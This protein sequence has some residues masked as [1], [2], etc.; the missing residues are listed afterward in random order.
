[1]TVV[2]LAASVNA[3]LL[4][5]AVAGTVALVVVA[6]LD[7]FSPAPS[8]RSS[9]SGRNR[10]LRPDRGERA[11]ALLVALAAV[12]ALLAG[13][14]YEATR[15]GVID[16]MVTFL[17]LAAVPLASDGMA[18]TGGT[19][20]G[21]GVLAAAGEYALAAFGHDDDLA[22]AM[23][24]ATAL[25]LVCGVAGSTTAGRALRVVSGFGIAVGALL[26]DP[27]P[28]AGRPVLTPALLLGLFATDAL[29][30]TFSRLRRRLPLVAARS[31][32]LPDRLQARGWRRGTAIGFLL[33]AQ[34]ALSGLAVF[35]GRAVLATWIAAVAGGALV[36]LVG[37][38]TVGG[39]VA[40]AP[41]RRIGRWVAVASAIVVVVLIAGLVP[42]GI[43]AVHSYDSMKQGRDDA[44]AGLA[45]AR[46]GDTTAA[47]QS[48]EAA[49]R[50]FETAGDKLRSP[51]V[52]PSSAV[53]Y[54]ASNVRAARTLSSIGT[55]LANAGESVTAA[56]Q[57]SALDIVDGRLPLEEVRQIT[58]TLERGARVLTDASR[59]LEV[60]RDD[61]YLVPQIRDAVD[62][63]R[64]QLT[65][66][67]REAGHAAKAA[68][69][70]PALFGGDGT[71][72]YLLVVQNN[73][74]SRATGGFIG[75][76]GVVTADNGKLDVGRLDRTA[77]WNKAVADSKPTLQAPADYLSRYA[78]YAPEYTLQNVNL[79]PDFPTVGKVLMSL[80]P[81]AGI[82]P[83][84][85][86]MAVDPAGLAALLELTGPVEVEGWPTPISSEN[87]VDIALKQEY[88]AF[89]ETPERADF[90]GD[91]A[92]AAVDKAT[93]ENLGRP[94]Q[95][96]KVLGKA[97]HE[98]HFVFA[99]ARPEEQRLAETL[100]IAGGL[101]PARPDSLAITTSNAGANKIDV[102]LQRTVTANVQL[103]P[104][105]DGT[106]A[107][108][109][110][111]VSV[112]L[113]NSAPDDGLPQIVIGPYEDGYVAG[114][115]RTILSL[116]SPMHIDKTA[117][118]SSPAAFDV[119]TERGR[120]VA[121]SF[122]DIPS[123]STR[124][125]SAQLDGTAALHRG[126]Y[127]LHLYH[128]PT[129]RPDDVRIAFNVPASWRIDQAVHAHIDTPRRA[130][131]HLQLERPTTVRLHLEPSKDASLWDRLNASG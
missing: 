87:V 100:G 92:Q 15:I 26:V 44:K 58:P 95:V 55:D 83:V 113:A 49:A 63:V 62:S 47:R 82:G 25:A 18:R 2:P 70:A 65:K 22:L 94:P 36:L 1:V 39:S 93:S 12:G 122:I 8:S 46:D 48:F 80:A 10:V 64:R 79:S 73:A 67:R 31:D 115:N 81:Q 13:V 50:E 23:A 106:S 34:A 7:R 121:S 77:T 37:I 128:Q 74:E 78:Q 51:L 42:T 107:R 124:T 86:V 4:V 60:V 59:R 30:V 24:G 102:Y 117:V 111:T 38:L 125:A 17:V 20:A 29:I 89:A 16:V 96:A 19:I 57:P 6:L 71:R 56:V 33:V 99:F 114:E 11:V 110:T 5:F 123:K 66:A 72:R 32:H 21:V 75:N 118:D 27:V 54:V 98:G 69:L 105:A 119:Q 3:A 120:Q 127:S 76:Y 43:A 41:T 88:E 40:P 9:R 104:D 84:D 90:L 61:P 109:A 131:T 28:G 129:Y 68:R 53:P 45:A 112:G 130:S 97:A 35:S 91:V 126:W 103:T 85:G 101:G 108:V 14:R 116:Y 52:W